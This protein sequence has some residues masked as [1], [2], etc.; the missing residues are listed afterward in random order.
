M[1]GGRVGRVLI[2]ESAAALHPH[3]PVKVGGSVNR[4]NPQLLIRPRAQYPPALYSVLGRI[5]IADSRPSSSLTSTPCGGG[6]SP[7]SRKTWNDITEGIDRESR[8]NWFGIAE[9]SW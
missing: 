7:D 9:L 8:N 3:V 6:R 5:R 2:P 1:A 4:G